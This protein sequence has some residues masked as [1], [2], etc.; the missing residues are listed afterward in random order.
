M[1]LPKERVALVAS[2][3]ATVPSARTAGKIVIPGGKFRQAST[4]GRSSRQ[5][6]DAVAAEAE[7]TA[8]DAE[9]QHNGAGRLDVRGFRELRI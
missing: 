7:A 3:S 4:A 6:G 5:D 2:T 9:W 8:T 1:N